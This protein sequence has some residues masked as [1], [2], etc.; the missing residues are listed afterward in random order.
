MATLPP[1]DGAGCTLCGRHARRGRSCVQPVAYEQADDVCRPV[2]STAHAGSAE[3]VD[4]RGVGTTGRSWTGRHRRS[5]LGCAAALRGGRSRPG[6]TLRLDGASIARVTHASACTSF[7]TSKR[8]RSS[9]TPSSGVGPRVPTRPCS[10]RH[11][12]SA[13]T[14]WTIRRSTTESC[15]ALG[16]AP[17]TSGPRRQRRWPGTAQGSPPG[18]DG[19]GVR[20]PGAGGRCDPRPGSRRWPDGA[21]TRTAS[22]TPLCVRA[23]G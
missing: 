4:A 8:S 6:E 19:G 9:V 20:N 11:R 1:A 16:V 17:P 22:S 5:G 14:T 10:H 15:P 3:P 2:I 13:G 21:E 23:A 18:A 7:Q 12:T